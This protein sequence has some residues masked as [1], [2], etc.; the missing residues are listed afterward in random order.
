MILGLKGLSSNIDHYLASP[1]NITA[2]TNA[3]VMRIKKMNI[4]DQ[5]LLVSTAGNVENFEENMHVD[6][7]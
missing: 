2:G 5:V 3:Q 1:Y 4:K 7:A 6:K